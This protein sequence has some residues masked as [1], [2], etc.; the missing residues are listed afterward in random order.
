MREEKG[1]YAMLVVTRDACR[2]RD[3]EAQNG[4]DVG[5]KCENARNVDGM[6]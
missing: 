4:D 6:R 2:E 3:E 1:K 5:R